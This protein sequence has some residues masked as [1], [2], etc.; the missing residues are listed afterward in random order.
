MATG[1]TNKLRVFCMYF[2]QGIYLPKENNAAA[3]LALVHEELWH[4]IQESIIYVGP[5]QLGRVLSKRTY[6]IFC[7]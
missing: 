2:L 7:K 3:S 5:E 4:D 1:E 6:D